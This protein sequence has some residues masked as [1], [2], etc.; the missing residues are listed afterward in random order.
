M[1]DNDERVF[2]FKQATALKLL[3]SVG[4]TSDDN[5]PRKAAETYPPNAPRYGKTSSAISSGGSGTVLFYK[6]KTTT[7]YVEITTD[8]VTAYSPFTAIADETNVFMVVMYGEWHVF[9]IC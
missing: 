9:E 3:A 4:A 6:H 5:I 7:P 1:A 8:E 2:G